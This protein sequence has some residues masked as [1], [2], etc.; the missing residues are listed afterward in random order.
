[1][2]NFGD[3]IQEYYVRKFRANSALRKAEI[4][5]LKTAGDARKFIAKVR[6]RIVSGYDF[7]AERC[8]LNPRITGT[9]E[10]EDFTVENVIFDSRPAFPVTGNVYLPKKREGK[11]PGVLF[12]CGHAQEGKFSD[13]YQAVM[14][15]LC[16]KGCVV[17][18]ID[19]IG[20]GER[21]QYPDDEKLGCCSEHNLFNRRML[22][23]GDNMSAWRVYD[24]IRGLD[25]LLS[26][27]E[28]DAS[29]VGVTGNSGGG[30]LTTLV[31]G[32]DDRFT[33]AAP[34]CYITRWLRNV[35]NELPVDAEQI[36]PFAGADGGEMAD[37]LIAQ[38]PR[39]LL[40]LGQKN[41]FFDIR[42]T[43]EVYEEVRK[44][45]A[46]LGKE[47]NVSL[48]V[49]P[50]N[51]GYSIHNREAAYGF[52]GRT[53]GLKADAKEPENKYFTREELTCAPG[54]RSIDV[55]GSLTVN[56][57]IRKRTLETIARR[58]KLSPAEL[59]AELKKRLGIGEVPVPTY[60]QLRGK[61]DF[62]A[63]MGFSRFGVETEEHL[64]C[65][66][67]LPDQYS[68][69]QH[70]PG[71]ARAELYIPHQSAQEEL[72]KRGLVKSHKVFGFDYR[73]VG[74]SMPDGC[75][76]G[77]REFFAY[78]RFDY[79]YASLALLRHESM[80]GRRV[81]DV[82]SAIKLLK[83]W[84]TQELMLTSSG[85]GEIPALLAAFLTDEKI[86][87][88]FGERVRTWRDSALSTRDML[89]QSMG[90][91]DILSLTDLDEIQDLVES[92]K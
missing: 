20:Q 87:P 23:S 83:A 80:L 90:E 40:I 44:I 88:V 52:F 30:T 10:R 69:W 39:P 81:F 8:P 13:T 45:Y 27:P 54:G 85:I 56:D 49:G 29:R 79:H 66:M 57:Y 91:F 38:A 63:Q 42:G 68:S 14:I 18:S 89:P 35:E 77:A 50:T 32:V 64:I 61:H 36:P 34:S 86:T 22:L 59:R 92:G 2:S 6:A 41:D 15:S 19:P 1:M 43:R 5:G 75:D 60:R 11:V 76:Q 67:I 58:P 71:E 16:R 3:L 4:D 26:R 24:A 53:F 46:L 37:F 65:T 47:E 74:E 7:P 33:A 55:P 51:H 48:F 25:Y 21:L 73:G 82:L 78:Y 72:T 62:T 9:L 17:L 31:A 84:G 70:I 12:L 28:V